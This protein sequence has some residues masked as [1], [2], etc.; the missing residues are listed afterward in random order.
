MTRVLL[1]RLSA[2]GDVV[3][4]LG[5]VR[6]LHAARPELELFFV[7]QRENAPLLQGLPGIA[8]VVA[9]DR[10]GG[11]AA[12]RRT[13][14][15]V[16]ALRCDV[17]LDLQGNWK[18]SACA[19]LAGCGRRIGVAGPSRQEPWSRLLLTDAVDAGGER[20]PA[21]VALSIVQ[22]LAPNAT[23]Q[24]PQLVA[25]EVEIR[26][27]ERM[28][29]EAGIEASLP[30]AVVLLG[31]PDDPRSLRPVAVRAAVGRGRPVLLVVGPQERD[32]E[33]P[34]ALPVLRQHPGEL[35][36]LVGLGALVARLGGE[37]LGAD[38]GPTHVLAAT[39][40]STSVLFGPQDPAFTAPPS[41]KVLQHGSPPTC[42]P[43]RSARC[44][45]PDGPLC[46]EFAVDTGRAAAPLDWQR[47]P[48]A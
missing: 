5:A 39:G 30:F 47:G 41:A 36:A 11:V 25:T 19:W 4:A 34:F 22:A 42:M 38:Q 1:V 32:L 44:S 20:H 31:R 8:G 27:A 17:A 2:M 45:H 43:C 3:Q 14:A 16:R 9:H 35:R 40:A 18:S 15:A 21:R 6:S 37:V 23:W 24:P 28:V 29:R 46:M 10:R 12:W 33:V 7:T 13:R 26:T 48:N